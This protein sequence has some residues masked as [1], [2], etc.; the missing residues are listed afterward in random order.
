[1][2]MPQ[3]S[4]SSFKNNAKRMFVLVAGFLVR[5]T[6]N[7]VNFFLASLFESGRFVLIKR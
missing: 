4:K 6:T 7:G 1:M 5:I 3:I 2:L